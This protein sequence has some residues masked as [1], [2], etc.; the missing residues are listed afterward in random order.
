MERIDLGKVNRLP[1]A[2]LENLP[3]SIGNVGCYSVHVEED[4]VTVV[5]QSKVAR[6]GRKPTVMEISTEIIRRRGVKYRVMGY[7]RMND[8]Y[9]GAGVA[10]LV[11][12]LVAKQTGP[13]MSGSSQSGGGR[14]IWNTL[15]K[16][17]LLT[18]LANWKGVYHEVES[19]EFGEVAAYNFSLYSTAAR[20]CAA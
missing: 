12:E 16:R 1:A 18:V 7:T 17:G 9:R 5:D 10:A 3:E 2:I 15:A 14:S 8:A 11:Y 19:T 4:C 6:R 20:L 13:I